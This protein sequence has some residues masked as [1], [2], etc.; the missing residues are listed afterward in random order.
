L[1]LKD[2][3]IL[4]INSID[5]K[6]NKIIGQ[7]ESITMISLQLQLSMAP[8]IRFVNLIQI[9]IVTVTQSH[10]MNNLMTYIMT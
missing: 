3:K 7:K 2:K 4:I 8:L 9:R 5:I 10:I 1:V 6:L